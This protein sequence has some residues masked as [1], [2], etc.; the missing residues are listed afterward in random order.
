MRGTKEGRK[1]KKDR[2]DHGSKRK[3]E[4]AGIEEE[5]NEEREGVVAKKVHGCFNPQEAEG[6]QNFVKSK[7]E[8]ILDEMKSTK[9]LINPVRKFIWVLK[10]EYDVIGLFESNGAVNTEDIVGTIPDMKGLAW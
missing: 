6:F 1:P 2:K 10:V 7:M 5:E 9:D 8:G 4:Q 3:P